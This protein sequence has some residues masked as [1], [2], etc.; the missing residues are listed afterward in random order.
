M[1]LGYVFFLS[2]LA[3]P[4][5]LINIKLIFFYLIGFA[6]VDADDWLEKAKLATTNWFG[7]VA[8]GICFLC[9]K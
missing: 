3:R 8:N 2:C 4:V 5:C 1:Y 7:S 6:D 9:E